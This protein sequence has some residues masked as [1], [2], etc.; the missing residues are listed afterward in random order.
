MAGEV[1]R[2]DVSALVAEYNQIRMSVTFTQGA[3]G[4]TGTLPVNVTNLNSAIPELITLTSLRNGITDLFGKFSSNCDCPTNTD[5]NQTCENIQ[6]Q[7][8]CVATGNQAQCNPISNQ[9]CEEALCQ[10]D[11]TTAN[12]TQCTTGNQKN[13]TYPNQA[14]QTN[15][16]NQGCQSNQN[17]QR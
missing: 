1:N 2:A 4:G 12:Q 13:C 15:Q 8:E 11:C 10:M 7:S 5:C 16:N 9:A 14:C 3:A 6:C 17:N